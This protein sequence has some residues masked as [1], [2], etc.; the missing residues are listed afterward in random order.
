MIYKK[1]CALTVA[2]QKVEEDHGG[3][4]K[5]EGPMKSLLARM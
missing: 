3:E 5:R 4:E 1:A 2:C